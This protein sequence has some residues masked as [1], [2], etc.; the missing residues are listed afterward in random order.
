MSIIIGIVTNAC[1]LVASDGRLHSGAYYDKGKRVKNSVV[2]RDDFDKTFVSTHGKL[3]GAVAG[4]MRF[5]NMTIGEH[6]HELSR[7]KHF[8]AETSVTYLS[9]GL[10]EKLSQIP[11]YEIGFCFRKLDLLLVSYDSGLFRGFKIYSYRLFPNTDNTNI[12]MEAEEIFP[13]VKGHVAWKLFG[14]DASQKSIN[15]F[16]KLEICNMS[17]V[18]E[19]H[20]RGLLYK[21]IRFGIRA[22]EKN[23]DGTKSNCGGK[24]FVKSIK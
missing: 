15:D 6:L 23:K 3:I 9:H 10:K 16:L 14:D 4:T 21:A 13:K 5:C 2:V 18:N 7:G 22:S 17:V 8:T 12:E 19:K 11:D 1:G 24:V 20:L